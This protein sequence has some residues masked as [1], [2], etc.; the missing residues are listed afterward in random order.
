MRSRRRAPGDESGGGERGQ[1]RS[2][3]HIDRGRSGRWSRAAKTCRHLVS[4]LLTA[5]RVL[6]VICVIPSRTAKVSRRSSPLFSMM[7]K[8]STPGTTSPE[9]PLTRTTATPQATPTPP[10]AGDQ[11]FPMQFRGFSSFA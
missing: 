4:S 6:L 11:A 3:E 9:N 8:L 5:S 7:D 1:G 2:D 10:L